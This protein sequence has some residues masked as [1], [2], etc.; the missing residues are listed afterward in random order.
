MTDV[1]EAY[2]KKALSPAPAKLIG[3]TKT[4]AEAR[5]VYVALVGELLA[6]RTLNQLQD[7][8]A[9]RRLEILQIQAEMEFL[10]F[11]DGHDFLGLEREIETAFE[12]VEAAS[13]FRRPGSN[14]QFQAHKNG[15]E[16]E[17]GRVPGHSEQELEK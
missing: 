8:L 15:S 3:I 16:G 7:V 11:G 10:W 6:C 9:A 2:A 14:L 1:F 17:A 5:A 13:Y 4:R 12:T